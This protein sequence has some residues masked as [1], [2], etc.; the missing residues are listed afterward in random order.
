[1]TSTD[2]ERLDRLIRR[3]DWLAERV[4]V[5]RAQGKEA[6][7]DEEERSA[8]DWAIEIVAGYF[9]EE[10]SSDPLAQNALREKAAGPRKLGA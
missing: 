9:E 2:R 8:L 3:R 5:R 6:N 1:M 10:E 4:N 7:Y